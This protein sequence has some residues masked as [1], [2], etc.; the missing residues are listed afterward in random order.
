MPRKT[1]HERF[2]EKVTILG[3]DDCWVW[4]AGL[5]SY[6]Y[7]KFHI[8]VEGKTK[9]DPASRAAYRLSR[10]YDPDRPL[11]LPDW[12]SVCHT[13]DNRVCCNPS[14]LFLGTNAENCAD[15]AQ[16][17]RGKPLK[18]VTTETVEKLRNEYFDPNKI[19]TITKL[20]A[21]YGLPRHQVSD[22]IRGRRRATDP[23]PTSRGQAA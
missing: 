19:I 21:L 17:K 5:N 12:L 2:W 1:V 16:K 18:F 14:H 3:P 6:G 4:N 23:G 13:C 7:G 20:A 9:T 8:I 22:I 15:R 11:Y 10:T